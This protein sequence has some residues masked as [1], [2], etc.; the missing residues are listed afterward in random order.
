MAS[1]TVLTGS[2]AIVSSKCSVV[3]GTLPVLAEVGVGSVA[4]GF[5]TSAASPTDVYIYKADSTASDL[6]VTFFRG[7]NSIGAAVLTP[8]IAWSSN[9]NTS[10]IAGWTIAAGSQTATTDYGWLIVH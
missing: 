8:S 10:G 4:T 9:V 7:T 3:S 6:A 2:P 5:W 1:S